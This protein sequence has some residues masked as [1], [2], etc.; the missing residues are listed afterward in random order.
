MSRLLKKRF[1]IINSKNGNIYK[2]KYFSKINNEIYINNILPKKKKGWIFHL[3]NTCNLFLIYGKARILLVDKKTNKIK[4]IKLN[5]NKYYNNVVVPPKKWF[6]LENLSNNS[7]AIFLNIL[8]GKH[9]SKESLKKDVY[10]YKKFV[11]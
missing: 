11:A 10:L 7:E 4:K 1:K 9:S 6:A 2:I 3:K 8:S 5:V